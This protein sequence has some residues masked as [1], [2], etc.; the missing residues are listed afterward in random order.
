MQRRLARTKEGLEAVPGGLMLSRSLTQGSG[1]IMFVRRVIG[2]HYGV[3]DKGK[4]RLEV[5]R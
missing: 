4:L 5:L 3:D 1:R 2:G